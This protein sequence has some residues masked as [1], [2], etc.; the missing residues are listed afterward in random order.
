MVLFLERLFGCSIGPK[1][2]DPALVAGE[3]IMDTS[4]AIHY[5][6]KKHNEDCSGSS[7]G[8]FF[9]ENFLML[10][11]D[12]NLKTY[13][14]LRIEVNL[15]TKCLENAAVE[16]VTL[17]PTEVVQMMAFHL[18]HLVHPTIHTFANWGC[19]TKHKD[20]YIMVAQKKELND[21]FYQ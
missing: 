12:G 8:V 11:N 21:L 3:L 20:R 2:W 15:E 13:K 19:N 7:I 5:V 4:E 17:T 16:G 1:P 10:N 18:G 6:G 14:F 9:W